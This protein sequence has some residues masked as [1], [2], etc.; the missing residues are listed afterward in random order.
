MVEAVLVV[1]VILALVV[2]PLSVPVFQFSWATL[3]H[4]YQEVCLNPPRGTAS[5][6]MSTLNRQ[7]RCPQAK[8]FH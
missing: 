2:V 1:V 8:K 6:F 4:F 7:I 5:W 3:M